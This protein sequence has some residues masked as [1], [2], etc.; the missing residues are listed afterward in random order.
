MRGEWREGRWATD[1]MQ[2]RRWRRIS[3]SFVVVGGGV[4]VG[5]WR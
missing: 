2:R 5:S 4:V 3:W 1:S